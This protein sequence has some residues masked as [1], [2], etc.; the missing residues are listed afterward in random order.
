MAGLTD[1]Y[2]KV[3]VDEFNW[4]DFGPQPGEMAWQYHSFEPAEKWMEPDD[5]LGRFR[6]V[7]FPAGMDE[8]FGLSFD[9]DAAGWKLGKAPFGAADDKT[10]MIAGSRSDC[11]LSFCKCGEP[12]QSLWEDDVLLMRGTFD[13]PTFEEGYRYRLLHGGISHV[14]S[15]GGYRLY[16]NGKLFDENKRGVDRRGGARPIG[17][18]IPKEWWPDFADGQATLAAMSFKKHHPRSKKYGGNISIFMQRMKVPPLAE[19]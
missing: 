7:T 8:W 12:V 3:G 17:R 1:L 5:R 2:R 6:E 16:V 4:Q 9:P 18:V 10:G 13:F 15:G 19:D 14:G 11:A